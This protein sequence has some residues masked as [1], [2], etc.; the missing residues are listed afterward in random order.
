[1]LSLSHKAERKFSIGCHGLCFQGPL[2][3]PFQVSIF[4]F[5]LV[6]GTQGVEVHALHHTLMGGAS[7]ESK[8]I[9]MLG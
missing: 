7:Q 2:V 9:N 3:T 6:R 5:G 8:V 1:M 4:P